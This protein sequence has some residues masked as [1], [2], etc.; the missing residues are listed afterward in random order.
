MNLKKL[1]GEKFKIGPEPGWGAARGAPLV[2]LCRHGHIF[3]NG[4][5]LG[6]STKSRGPVAKRLAALSCVQVVQDGQDGLNA[7]FKVA[8]F[9]T[10]AAVMLP[11]TRHRKRTPEERDRLAVYH[12][13]PG[14]KR[15]S[16]ERQRA[17]I[18][19]V[20]K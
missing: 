19:E 14:A 10:V 11:R 9:D 3:D 13:K 5:T 16:S 20:V 18:G 1:F 17:P 8:D 7:I 2:I 4:K 12:F 15:P 6:A